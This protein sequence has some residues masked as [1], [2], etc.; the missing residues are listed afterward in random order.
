[1][2][3]VYAKITGPWI[4]RN[5]IRDQ[6][7]KTLDTFISAAVA[8][9]WKVMDTTVSELRPK[10]EPTIK[11]MVDPI[12]KLERELI[13]KIKAGAM[14][15][16]TPILEE[17]VKPHVSKIVEVIKSPMAE[18]YADAYRIWDEKVGAFSAKGSVEEVKKEFHHIDGIYNCWDLWVACRKVDVMYEPLWAMNIIFP[19]IWP[20]SL[21]WYAHDDVRGTTD[22]AVY[23]FEVKILKALEKNP[24]ACK[25]EGAAKDLFL[26]KKG[27][28]MEKFKYDGEKATNQYYAEI[29]KRIVFPP[30]NKLVIP[31]CK[32]IISPVAD[33]IPEPMKQFVDPYQLF[34]T[35]VNE[36]VNESIQV[37]LRG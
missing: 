22:D 31:A 16:I 28:V 21:I 4:I 34:D 30:F 33:L 15:V 27:K 17:H 8:P 19:D 10:I 3:R 12:G 26:T 32:E 20:W 35:L 9:S 36:I 13:D 5:K 1:M 11:E 2:G 18:A 23:T 29:I 7:L 37:V 14:S 6:V 24:D 25:D